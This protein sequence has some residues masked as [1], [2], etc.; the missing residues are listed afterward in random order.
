MGYVNGNNSCTKTSIL[1][2]RPFTIS[3]LSILPFEPSF[4]SRYYFYQK[5][6]RGKRWKI[7]PFYP[8][9]T[10][11]PEHSLTPTPTNILKPTSHQ[12]STSTLSILYHIPS[13]GTLY[14][15]E[16][17]AQL[18]KCAC[19]GKNT[20]SFGWGISSDRR[21]ICSDRWVKFGLI[22]IWQFGPIS[23]DRTRKCNRWS[24]LWM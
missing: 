13:Q 24:W 20:K 23:I 10:P 8:S 16:K 22:S 14:S 5:L 21:W 18:W 6:F 11:L 9:L 1:E 15:D 2:F 4:S 7:H 19:V 3:I 17:G 12:P